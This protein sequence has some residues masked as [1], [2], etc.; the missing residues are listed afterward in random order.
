VFRRV[1]RAYRSIFVNLDRVART[2][3]QF[4]PTGAFVLDIGGG[5]GEPLNHLLA[6]RSDIR[7]AMIDLSPNI[8]GFIEDAFRSRVTVLPGT[9]IRTYIASGARQPDV[10]LISD[11]LH[12]VPLDDRDA[13][14]SDLRDLAGAKPDATIIIKDVEPGGVRSTLG[15]L[16]DRF[17]SGDPG[18]S[19]ISRRELEA[20]LTAMFE[21]PTIHTPLYD[22][23]PPNYAL[24]CKSP[25]AESSP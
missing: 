19:L 22:L 12:H 7:V 4:I 11:V 20:H 14:M 8:G 13:F 2:S 21:G 9:S 17:I 15:Y 23:D 5:D 3:A 25:A 6:L 10:V 1:G 18:V 24:V 16:A